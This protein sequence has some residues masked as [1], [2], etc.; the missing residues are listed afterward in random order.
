M[1]LRSLPL[2]L[3]AALLLV[4]LANA[5]TL[6]SA[7]PASEA[8]AAMPLR[9]ERPSSPAFT[10]S[11]LTPS[12]AGARAAACT[13]TSEIVQAAAS[14]ADALT[15]NGVGY[16]QSFTAP[17][18]GVLETIFQVLNYNVSPNTPFEI[19]LT[20]YAGSG[21][22]GTLLHENSFSLV[23]EA[24][25]ASF[26]PFPISGGLPVVQGQVY[27]FFLQV[28]SGTTGV[29]G[30]A[31]DVYAGGVQY[32][33][34]D[35]NPASAT[36]FPTD[37]NQFAATFRTYSTVTSPQ[38]FNPSSAA[39][40]GDGWRLLAS[41]VSALTLTDL[42]DQN[43]L[44]GVAAGA[45]DDNPAQYP[46]AGSNI[47]VTYRSGDYL[48]GT[49]VTGTG[50]TPPRGLGYFWYL[51]DQDIT[52]DPTSEGTGTSTSVELT[53]F[54]FS[55][56]GAAATANVSTPYYSASTDGEYLLGNPF[57]LPFQLAGVSE[58]GLGT[59]F[60]VW[61]PSVGSFD[62]LGPTDYV[63]PWQGF[64]ATSTTTATAPTF[65]YAFAATDASQDP[66]FYG[67]SA[68]T[69]EAAVRFRL[70]GE[71]A[72]G[73]TVDLAAV[74]RFLDGAAPGPGVHDGGKILPPGSPYALVAPVDGSGDE[75][76]Y[77]SVNSLPATGEAVTV[78]VAFQTTA[79]GTF[80]LTWENTLEAGR[81]AILRDVVTGAETDLATVT[82]YTF[83]AEA[84]DWT[85]RFELVMSV[86][87]SAE[88]GP[89]EALLSAVAPNPTRGTAAL[90]LR[91]ATPQAVRAT[92]VDALGRE[93]AVLFEGDVSPDAGTRLTVDASALAPGVYV[94][95]V[96]GASFDESRRL[97]VVR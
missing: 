15:E 30:S 38:V 45:D 35:G 79:A 5:Q 86:V 69:D 9:T 60:Q 49:A 2:A 21:T 64:F 6:H 74:V 37:D 36:A 12:A 96:E 26:F 90:T 92:L 19:N 43:L 95:R 31:T 88:D 27:T 46:T 23:N 97:T 32:Y 61:D 94:V 22:L 55:A 56:T 87:V 80:T 7:E 11:P 91:V 53:G 42:A 65:V 89:A 59:V 47:L 84:S 68:A 51:Y 44:Q 73:P 67:R 8:A 70:D 66:T 25:G 62:L 17:C 85:E 14:Y 10:S 93:V 81:T 40:D 63:A 50:F 28:T 52:P 83:E 20:V 1:S 48:D 39:R 41:P 34:T 77:L 16:G 82:E 3:A 71:T 54:Q 18:D 29:Q 78:P 72:S 13:N 33:N 24:G 57:A 4:P 75:A 58:T 76:R